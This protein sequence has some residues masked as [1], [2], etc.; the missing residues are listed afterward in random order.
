MS[1]NAQILSTYLDLKLNGTDCDNPSSR[2]FN[3]TKISDITL[4]LYPFGV[5]FVGIGGLFFYDMYNKIGN[6]WAEVLLII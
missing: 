2:A 3:V 1:E 5:E 6:M 4:Y